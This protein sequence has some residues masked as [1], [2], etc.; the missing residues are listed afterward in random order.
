M[1]GYTITEQRHH[2]PRKQHTISIRSIIARSEAQGEEPVCIIVQKVK[3][4]GVRETIASTPKESRSTEFLRR[5]SF[6]SDFIICFKINKNCN[7]TT[8]W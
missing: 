5:S 8:S 3:R 4:Q 2:I 6:F 7:K 1:D